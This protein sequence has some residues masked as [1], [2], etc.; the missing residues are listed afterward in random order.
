MTLPLKILDGVV[1]RF[2]PTDKLPFSNLGT[3]PVSVLT[4]SA[5]L[6]GDGSVFLVNAAGGDLTVTLPNTSLLTGRSYV[7]KKIDTT[8]NIITINTSDGAV[9]DG[10]ISVLMDSPFTSL[11]FVTDGTNWYII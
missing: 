6:P 2:E 7:I 1:R 11:T 8:P 9:I 3:P 10:Q 4:A 5:I